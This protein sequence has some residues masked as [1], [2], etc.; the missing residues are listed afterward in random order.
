MTE[1]AFVFPS[2]FSQEMLYL[3]DRAS[4]GQ[5]LY[6]IPRARR[7]R[8]CLE[9]PALE[10]ALAALAERHEILRTRFA[11]QDGAVV[12]LVR[13]AGV[14]PLE[15]ADLRQTNPDT[16]EQAAARL[17]SEAGSR[18][19]D[20]TC[21]MMLRATLYRLAD[22]D[23]VLLLVTHH[24]ASDG[25]SGGILFHD[26]F[27]LYL[28]AVEGRAPDLAPLAIQFGDFAAW[29]RDELTGD[30]LAGLRQYWTTKLAGPLPALELPVDRART[31]AAGDSGA[32]VSL[33]IEP[34]VADRI[35]KLSAAAGTSTYM[36]LLAAIQST[37]SRLCGADDVI[38]GSPVAGRDNPDLD[39]LMGFFANTVPLRT[40]FGDN[41]TFNQLL[42]RVRATCLDGFEHH[43]MPLEL[44]LDELKRAGHLNDPSLFRVV[45][46]MLDDTPP[47]REYP[48]FRIDSFRL[49]HDTTK[50]DLTFFMREKGESIGMS[51]VYRTDL[52]DASTAT[53]ILEV[54][55]TLLCGA[56]DQP[57][58]PVGSLP[59]LSAG[60]L[61]RIAASQGATVA[62]APS[63]VADLIRARAAS[64]PQAIAVRAGERTLRY[65]D[66]WTRSESLARAL[67]DAG[68]ERHDLV[69]LCLDRDL[70]L[71]VA[72]M[73]I[74]RA[75]AAY[76]PLLPDL[77]TARLEQLVKESGARV[78][79]TDTALRERIPAGMP[80]ITA[81]G[82]EPAAGT[83]K[84]PALGTD[85]LAYV[86]FTS[87]STGIP[88][89]V[90]V[91]H[92][93]LAHY[94]RA[95][96]TR[97]GLTL[98]GAMPWSGA[99][100]STLAA[101]LGHTSVFP[102]LAAG[103]TVHLI[104]ANVAME[105]AAWEGY[106]KQHSVDLLKITPSHLRALIGDATGPA[107]AAV[108]PT[109]WLVVG[110]E[111]CPWTLVRSIRASG[112]GCRV[113]NHYGPTETTVGACT[114]APDEVDLGDITT[115][116]VPIGRP[117]ANMRAEVLDA[118]GERVPI[119]FAGEL[120]LGGP[121]VATGYLARPDLTAER[122]QTRDGTRWYRSGDRVR[123][124]AT[125]DIEFLGRLDGQVKV[126]G[127]RVELEEIE[128]VVTAIPGVTQSAVRLHQDELAG[129][130]VADPS[131]PDAELTRTVQSLLPDYMVPVSWTR[132]ERLP[133]NANGKLDRAA[134]PAPQG[135]AAAA[136]PDRPE[137]PVEAQLAGLFAE[138]LKRDQVARN[139]NFFS[140]G[141]HS[142]LA[143]RLLGRISK[144]FGVRLALRALFDAPTVAEL[145]AV[146]AP[147]NPVEAPLTALFADV[148]KQ[149]TVA[150]DASFFALGGHSLLAIRLLGRISRTF[151][152]RLAL[153]DLFEAPTPRLL[154]ELI[155]LEQQLA[156]A[157]AAPSSLPADG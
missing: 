137:G 143:I 69:G 111:T 5:A 118:C 91:T 81:D 93:N 23:S 76:V 132:L 96:S 9:L 44:L 66:L 38:V 144:T 46:T 6:N 88:K 119:G 53:R 35:R 4:P 102:I 2:T 92:G 87:G 32:V 77:P 51:L 147:P 155:D 149:P 18:P 112:A 126:R 21:D 28:A 79:V 113:L 141:G 60:G 34:A 42:A 7:I 31:S 135:A 65:G 110:G 108:L 116:S 134:L 150:R 59:L 128:R 10:R 58:T 103:G 94:V 73:G 142:L 114:F 61:D 70:D 140:L 49:A 37:L 29:Q 90:A 64:T 89:G 75:G 136:G 78:V 121:Q 54:V 56:L 33:P 109:R 36:V 24:V 57:D 17:A 133:L 3:V 25:W 40:R 15:V 125:G 120:W 13:P 115:G 157:N 98:D 30:R 20:L 152:I 84:L 129:Y 63:H 19:F 22:D 55:H 153:R 43:E 72:V 83:R 122:F 117:L 80:V 67:I 138:V 86:L 50:F 62:G 146:I 82:L 131:V 8:G 52:F 16:R 71:I 148:L 41:P 39:G 145:A 11:E 99:S 97:L 1:K 123:R 27:E 101:D 104:P 154:A 26:L 100:V 45:F 68:I 127:H 139:A 156:V 74:W 107:L 47:A 130:V 12:Q 14:I 124:I 106:L 105:P 95:V 48:G 151:G 85:D